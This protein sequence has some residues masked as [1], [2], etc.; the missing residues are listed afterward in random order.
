MSVTLKLIT[1]RNRLQSLASNEYI[2]T[3]AVTREDR[4]AH[5]SDCVT[6]SVKGRTMGV[7]RTICSK[8]LP[9]SQPATFLDDGEPHLPTG[10]EKRQNH[11]NGRGGGLGSEQA[12]VAD[13]PVAHIG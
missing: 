4:R 1:K 7:F 12:A 8:R 13:H 5:P 11:T 9:N 10:G 3:L 2:T 6:R